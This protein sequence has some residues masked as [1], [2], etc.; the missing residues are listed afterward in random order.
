MN[1]SEL[2]EQKWR[3]KMQIIENNRMNMEIGDENLTMSAL[4]MPELLP[5]GS[6]V[7]LRE[8]SK[9]IM[10]AGRMQKEKNSGEWFDYAAVL[11]PEGLI[12]SDRIFLFNRE[13][14]RLIHFIGL[15]DQQEFEFRAVLE[16]KWKEYSGRN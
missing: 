6:V 1:H 3:R 15:Q 5:L 2:K 7:T 10:I 4:E 8:G 13:D 16:E 12:R 14:I 9:R 11:W